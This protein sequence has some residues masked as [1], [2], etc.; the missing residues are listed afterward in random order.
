MGRKLEILGPLP[1]LDEQHLQTPAQQIALGRGDLAGQAPPLAHAATRPGEQAIE[2][3]Q[4]AL[5]RMRW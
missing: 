4:Q 1:E 5:Q 3:M 2:V